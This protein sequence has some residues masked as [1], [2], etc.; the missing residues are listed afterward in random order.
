MDRLLPDR[1]SP[2]LIS[3]SPKRRRSV[4]LASLPNKVMLMPGLHAGV[5]HEKDKSTTAS[6]SLQASAIM[7]VSTLPPCSLS[8]SLACCHPLLHFPFTTLSFTRPSG[9]LFPAAVPYRT[10]AACDS[11]PWIQPRQV[12][13]SWTWTSSAAWRTAWPPKPTRGGSA[14]WSRRSWS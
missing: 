7:T 11:W 5:T 12:R 13:T 6:L 10:G 14:G 1:R 4:K 3:S 8:P 9:L 2:R